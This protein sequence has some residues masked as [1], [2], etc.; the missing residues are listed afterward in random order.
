MFFV[1]SLVEE[2]IVKSVVK[3]LLHLLWIEA[4]IGGKEL[5]VAEKRLQIGK[6]ASCPIRKQAYVGDD[7]WILGMDGHSNPPEEIVNS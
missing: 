4:R 6:G 5:L 1:P 3:Q 2:H 7:S